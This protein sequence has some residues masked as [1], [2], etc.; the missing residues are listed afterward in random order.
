[1]IERQMTGGATP[2]I[3]PEHCSVYDSMKRRLED[4]AAV[5][6][7]VGQSVAPDALVVGL[8]VDT[9]DEDVWDSVADI[10]F[11]T[12]TDDPE[13]ALVFKECD[14]RSQSL[15]EFKAELSPALAEL[16]RFDGPD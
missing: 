16:V 6:E 9:D 12:A 13:V 1:M 14:L 15:E 4:I 8:V 2:L 7:V 5:R 10:E 3:L 11:E